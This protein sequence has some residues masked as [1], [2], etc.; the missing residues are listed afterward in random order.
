V[1][2]QFQ[3][4]LYIMCLNLAVGLIF[5]LAN[6]GV[7][8]AG[9]EYV[10][11]TNPGNA[12]D[13]ES[14]FNATE[15]GKGWGSTPFM[16]IPVIGDIFGGFQ[17]LLTH[18]QFLIDGFPTFLMWIGDSYITDAQGRMAFTIIADALR[19]VYAVLMAFWFIEY[20]GGRFFAD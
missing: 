18:I 15:I 11:P 13:Y 10:Q 19:A 9:T 20:I 5:A 1:K 8:I 2:L 14:T 6:A 4:L 3:I 17:F 7:P 16:G 12:T